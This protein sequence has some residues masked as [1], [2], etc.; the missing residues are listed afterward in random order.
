MPFSFHVVRSDSR[1]PARL[2]RLETPHGTI[3]TPVF[4][5]VGTRAAVKG[6]APRDLHEAGAEILL[7]NTYHLA[8]RPGDDVIAELG[9]LHTF[10]GWDRPLLTDSGGFQVFSLATLRSVDDRGVTFRSHI[11]GAE[12]RLDPARAVGIQ[13]NLGADIIMAFDECV[14]L[15]AADGALERAVD[16]SVRWAGE[17]KRAQ[18]RTDQALF[19]IVQGGLDLDLRRRCLDALVEIDFPGYAV[20]GLA[21]GD[22]PDQMAQFL[23]QFVPH[24]PTDRPRYLMGVG[25]PIDI[26]RAVASGIDMFDCVMPTRNGRNAYAFVPDGFLRMRNADLRADPRP[27]QETC[28][29]HT[30]KHFSRGY[31]RHLF[32]AKEMLGPIL[33]SLHN[34]AYYQ[35]WMRRI[36]DAIASDTFDDMIR[37]C[38]DRA[39]RAPNNDEAAEC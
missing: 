10:M 1:T 22:T 28:D 11:D 7:A 3:D 25:R 9:G 38:E 33:V 39:S 13:E 2:G 18:T 37:Q 32:L 23:P 16:R 34:I 20:G 21:V 17:C 19:A 6:I 5:T 12:F 4:I 15:P 30:C 24:M 14:R 26:L 8:L 27:I 31:L 29:C 36:R 35:R